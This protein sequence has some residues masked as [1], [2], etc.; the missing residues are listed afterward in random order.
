MKTKLQELIKR[1]ETDLVTMNANNPNITVINNT[2]LYV[3]YPKE[4]QEII[5]ETCKEKAI[6]CAEHYQLSTLP[7]G[8][9]VVDES[10]LTNSP[11]PKTGIKL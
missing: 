6:I 8:M 3:I 9:Q 7:S 1:K 4:L 5:D 2:R 10:S 11:N